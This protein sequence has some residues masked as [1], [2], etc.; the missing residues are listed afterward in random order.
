VSSESTF[1]VADAGDAIN[2]PFFDIEDEYTVKADLW[3]TGSIALTLADF[4]YGVNQGRNVIEFCSNFAQHVGR[5]ARDN[6]ALVAEIMA[7]DRFKLA[8]QKF[9]PAGM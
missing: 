6:E 3:Q 1:R 9:G 4:F 7:T 5:M 8:V 2:A